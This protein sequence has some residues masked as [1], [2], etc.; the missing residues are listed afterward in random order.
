MSL[1]P[2]TQSMIILIT[3]LNFTGPS[4]CKAIKRMYTATVHCRAD[5]AKEFLGICQLCR[6]MLV[7]T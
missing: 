3:A 6:W 1:N 5:G 7:T 4:Q 2:V